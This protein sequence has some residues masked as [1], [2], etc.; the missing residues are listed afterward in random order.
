MCGES[1]VKRNTYHSQ[2]LLPL[3][4]MKKF[5]RPRRIVYDGLDY[6]DGGSFGSACKIVTLPQ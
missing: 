5:S 3:V 2:Q 1:N 4:Q 6:V